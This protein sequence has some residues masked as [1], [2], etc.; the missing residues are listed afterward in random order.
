VERDRGVRG[1]VAS[2][3]WEEDAHAHRS[4]TRQENED[5]RSHDDP[6]KRSSDVVKRPVPRST[7]R[8]LSLREASPAV[9]MARASRERTRCGCTQ[10][11]WVADVGWTHRA[12]S[13][14]FGRKAGW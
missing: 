12:P 1:S 8:S 6:P 5:T 2:A 14:P 4:A 9:K 10:F 3:P 7:A 13:S 11:D